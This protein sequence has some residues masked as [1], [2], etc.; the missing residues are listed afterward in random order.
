MSNVKFTKQEL[1]KFV[2][3]YT[4]EKKELESKLNH[5]NEMLA[6]LSGDV[7]ISKSKDTVVKL[8]AKGEIAKKRGPKSV[9]G[10]FITNRLAWYCWN[11]INN[12]NGSRRKCSNF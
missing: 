7:V 2:A 10:K 1:K 6:K 3:H 9:W 12:W 4:A 8:T 5:A 11:C